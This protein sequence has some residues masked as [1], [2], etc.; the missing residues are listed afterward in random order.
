MP[1]GRL[2]VEGVLT[3]SGVFEYRNADGTTRREYRPDAEV[4]KAAALATFQGVPVTND[5]PH[6][7][8]SPDTATG[9]AVGAVVGELRRDGALVVAPL[10][11][12]DAAT[13]SLM[14]AGKTAL[15]CGYDVDLVNEPGTAPSGEKYDAIQTNIR[16]NHLAVVERGR[17]GNLARVR[18]DAAGREDCACQISTDEA[19]PG[20]TSAKTAGETEAPVELKE[21]L[22][23]LAAS[24][25]RADAERA[26]ADKAE[27]RADTAE[28]AL[29]A[30][31]DVDVPAL[32][33]AR[34]ALV[35]QAQPVL[36]ADVRLDEMTDDQI[37]RAVIKRVDGDEIAAERSPEYVE[38][39]YN[40]A[41]KHAAEAAEAFA[42][43]ARIVEPKAGE[44]R[45]DDAKYDEA[46]AVARYT[47]KLAN[48]WKDEE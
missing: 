32:V 46:A 10:S 2:L 23:A 4:F 29:A 8:L 18:M 13:I 40:A 34:V 28:K 15:S 20:G 3:R 21:L 37:R 48:A 9:V 41:I 1:D 7:M 45:A 42:G 11:A 47:A 6:E 27:G 16:G 43:V 25:K 31:K 33:K 14:R 35:T 22:E 19:D 24:E 36:G 44:G 30:R 26:R 12:W 38:G 17:A 5:H 39:A